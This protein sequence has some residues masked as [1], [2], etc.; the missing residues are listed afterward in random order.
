M[1]KLEGD[2]AVASDIQSLRQA[3]VALA[4]LLG[5]AVLWIGVYPAP[6]ID[7]MHTSV[8]GLLAQVA[9]AK[10]VPGSP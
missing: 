4:F 3:K 10:F 5:A 2:Q 7:A 6:I 9:Q 8:A 1:Q